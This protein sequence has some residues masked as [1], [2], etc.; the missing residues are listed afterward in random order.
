MNPAQNTFIYHLFNTETIKF[1]SFPLKSGR[2]SPY[3]INVMKSMDTGINFWYVCY[4]YAQTIREIFGGSKINFIFGPAYKGIPLAAGIASTLSMGILGSPP[5]YKDPP[6]RWGY[7]RKEEKGYGDSTESSLVGDLRDGD[8]VLI[9]DDVVTTAATK[10][11]ACRR[12]LGTGKAIKIMGVLVGVD[13]EETSEADLVDLEKMGV[14]IYSI[15]TVTEI[16]NY[17]LQSEKISTDVYGE[18]MTYMNLQRL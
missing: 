5:I 16:F 18:C 14:K 2:I 8:R 11:E 9:V 6:I 12:L 10:I 1:G 7:D 13:R 17:L 15:I 4:S 3:F